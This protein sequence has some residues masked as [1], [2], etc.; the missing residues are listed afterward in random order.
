[1]T[2]HKVYSA[3]VEAVKARRLKEP[4]GSREFKMACPGFGE[5]TYHAFLYKHSKDNPGEASELFKKVAPGKFRL[6]R[7]FKYGL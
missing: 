6:I 5:G 2:Q 7:P 1:M 3:I 4:F